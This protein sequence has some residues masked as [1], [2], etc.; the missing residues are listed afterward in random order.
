MKIAVLSVQGAFIEHEKMLSLLGA[1]PLKYG[2]KEIW[3][4]NLTV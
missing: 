1:S 4:R 2:R 3:N